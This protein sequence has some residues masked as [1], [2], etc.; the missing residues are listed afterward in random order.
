MRK[1]F[2]WCRSVS[3]PSL[4]IVGA[5]DQSVRPDDDKMPRPVGDVAR[6][7]RIEGG[8]VP[9]LTVPGHSAPTHPLLLSSEVNVADDHIAKT[10]L[11]ITTRT[12]TCMHAALPFE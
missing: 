8:L 10:R 1:I 4:P 12:A 5:S 6:H 11:G 7:G 3:L 2:A 9:S